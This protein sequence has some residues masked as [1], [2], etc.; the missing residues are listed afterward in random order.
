MEVGKS[1]YGFLVSSQG[2]QLGVL[3]AEQHSRIEDTEENVKKLKDIAQAILKKDQTGIMETILNEEEVLVVFTPI[4]ETGLRLVMVMPVREAFASV[5]WILTQ[6]MI[7]LFASIL[8]LTLMIFRLFES[9]VSL[10][11]QRLSTH[12]APNRQWG[13]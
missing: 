9:K 6:N 5:R 3:T 4:G 10:P 13:F 7:V 2:T 12:A 8:V 1:G 11:L